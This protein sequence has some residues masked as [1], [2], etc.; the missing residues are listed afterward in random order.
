VRGA[1]ARLLRERRSHREYDA[2]L[3]AE[4]DNYA[5]MEVV[6]DLPPIFHYWSNTHVLPMLQTVGFASLDDLYTR[7]FERA[8]RDRDHGDTARFVSIGAGNCDTESRVARDLLSRGCEDFVIDCLELSPEMLERGMAAAK[9]AGTARHLRPLEADFNTWKPETRYDGVLANQSLHHVVNLEGLYDAIRRTMVPTGRFVTNDMVGRNGHLRWPE[10]KRVVASFWAEL[11]SS[12]HY[13]HVLRRQEAE[14]LDWDSSTEGFE[15]IRAQDVLPLLIERFHFEVFLAFGNVIDPFVDRGFGPNFDVNS[16]PDREFI[17]RVHTRDMEGLRSGELKPTHLMAVMRTAPLPGG[18]AVYDCLTPDFCVR[19]PE[20]SP[21]QSTAA[22][23][24]FAIPLSPTPGELD[25]QVIRSR[26][27]FLAAAER[28]A[29]RVAFERLLCERLRGQDEWTVPGLCQVCGEAVAFSGD[30]QFSDGTTV[31]FRERLVCPRCLLNNRQRFMAHVVRSAIRER[32]AASVYMYE[33]VTPFFAWAE[34]ELPARVV[35]SEYLGHDVRA[36]VVVDGVRHEDALALSFDDDAFDAVVS[37]DVFEHVPD[38]ERSL[39]ECARVLRDDGRLFF[40]IPFHVTSESTMKRAELRNGELVEL[41]PAEYHGNPISPG[42]SLVFY[43]H[44]W[45]IL[46]ACR[47]AG[48]R[49][50]YV[51]TYWSLLYGYLGGMQS[52]FVAEF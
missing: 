47:S 9:A 49:D 33:Q 43:D 20:A 32:P 31:N 30:W 34:R 10:A 17:D 12:Y 44:G 2:R 51:L 22:D 24:R 19:P 27:E 1:V 39:A 18:P 41:L 15:G 48:F 3:A 26:T 40:S 4:R 25:L 16:A 23:T 5:A 11:D 28:I 52:T 42:G 46:D 8:Y 37:N 7:P 21:R 50:A 36:G 38:I 14:F 45:E 13:N 29:D 35:G 6:H